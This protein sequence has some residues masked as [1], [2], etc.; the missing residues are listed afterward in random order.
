LSSDAV[1]GARIYAGQ[2][3]ASNVS[4]RWTGFPDYA[5][6]FPIRISDG[7]G[8]S[9]VV[10]NDLYVPIGIQAIDEHGTVIIDSVVP[11]RS[12][13]IRAPLGEP[14]R[15]TFPGVDGDVEFIFRN[16]DQSRDLRVLRVMTHLIQAVFSAIGVAAG[17]ESGAIAVEMI[18][19]INPDQLLAIR[20]APAEEVVALVGNVLWD[21][22]EKVVDAVI[23]GAN[24]SVQR[25]AAQMMVRQ[26]FSL[27]TKTDA[28]VVLIRAVPF[29]YDWRSTGNKS[30]LHERCQNTGVFQPCL[31]GIYRATVTITGVLY[32]KTSNVH[33][34]HIIKIPVNCTQSTSD[35]FLWREG[36]TMYVRRHGASSVDGLCNSIPFLYIP[37]VKLEIS[38]EELRYAG[39]GIPGPAV[40]RVPGQIAVRYTI[41]I[42]RASPPM[43]EQR[44]DVSVHLVRTGNFNDYYY[45]Y[46][47]N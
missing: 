43:P 36:R 4:K 6:K 15:R 22:R 47:D 17:G 1:H 5:R 46:Q 14:G 30:N 25:L 24:G 9:Y 29:Y 40:P 2:G 16:T 26:I 23:R 38:G 12:F 13:S 11:E 39:P 37:Q 41:I 32:E 31:R 44:L 18:G 8:S 20:N 28:V 42:S 10:E 34:I 27:W 21:H 35:V 45:V 19:Y 3:V 7:G 33:E